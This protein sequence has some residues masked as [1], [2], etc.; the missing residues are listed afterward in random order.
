[1]LKKK[2]SRQEYR[3]DSTAQE[4]VGK[5]R[6]RKLAWRSASCVCLGSPCASPY[7]TGHVP[8]LSHARHR[9]IAL[10]GAA[11]SPP[12]HTTPGR[13][14]PWLLL[15]SLR[16]SWSGCFSLLWRSRLALSSHNDRSQTAIRTTQTPIPQILVACSLLTQAYRTGGSCPKSSRAHHAWAATALV[17]SRVT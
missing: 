14:P 5:P 7:A 15:G 4:Y 13:R 2:N 6:W 3:A 1:M 17:S 8:S 9:L 12:A 10:V 16:W 11:T